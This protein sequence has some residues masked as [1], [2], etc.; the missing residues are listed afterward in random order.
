[1]SRMSNEEVI[2]RANEDPNPKRCLI[3]SKQIRHRAMTLLGQIMWNSNDMDHAK[4]VTITS[5]LE[6]VQKNYKRVGGHRFH[7]LNETMTNAYKV[8]TAKKKLRKKTFSINNQT[9]KQELERAAIRREY[10]FNKNE[11]HKK[12]LKRRKS[13][14]D[15]RVDGILRQKRRL[16][17]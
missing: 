17:P 6:R 12:Y 4:I 7:W 9:Q 11:S 13:R 10:P 8:R 14:R 5:D 1:M 3:A 2:K 15:K 16:K